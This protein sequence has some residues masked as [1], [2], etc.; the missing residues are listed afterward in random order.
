[1]P[2]NPKPTI[3]DQSFLDLAAK[4]ANLGPLSL[5]DGDYG[6]QTRVSI[7]VSG[8]LNSAFQNAESVARVLA[9]LSE[10]ILH[11][12]ALINMRRAL[13]TEIRQIERI[14]ADGI[15]IARVKSDV[16]Y[17]GSQFDTAVL[18]RDIAYKSRVLSDLLKNLVTARQEFYADVEAGAAFVDLRR[19]RRQYV[20]A[21]QCFEHP[22]GTAAP[23]QFF[24]GQHCEIKSRDPRG[25]LTVL[26]RMG[27]PS[28][29]TETTVYL[30]DAVAETYFNVVEEG[31]I[32]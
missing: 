9:E 23:I 19:P 27:I 7:V 12:T 8:V 21:K 20:V 6:D 3:V 15:D 32:S 16:Q 18:A 24:A 28:P 17:A 30:T 14:A 22:H 13:V 29:G 25:N 26:V 11:D 2:Q 4:F 1:M 5:F 31:S 10:E